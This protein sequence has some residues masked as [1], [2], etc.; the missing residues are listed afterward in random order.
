MVTS[1]QDKLKKSKSY[2]LFLIS[3]LPVSF[4]PIPALTIT[5]KSSYLDIDH[6][7]FS[8]YFFQCQISG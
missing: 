5:K 4:W 1:F 6:L 7:E 3:E 8:K 2:V